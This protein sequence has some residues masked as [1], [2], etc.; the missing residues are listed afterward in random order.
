M[1]YTIT[2]EEE[3]TLNLDLWTTE[4]NIKNNKLYELRI[5]KNEKDFFKV[6]DYIRDLTN[7]EIQE[8][9]KLM[10]NILKGEY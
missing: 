1:N 10:N 4:K 9:K 6:F 3:K 2:V 7:I 5:Y 8:R